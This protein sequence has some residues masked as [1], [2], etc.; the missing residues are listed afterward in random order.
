[1]RPLS[2]KTDDLNDQP[3]LPQTAKRLALPIHVGAFAAPTL[4][5]M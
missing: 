4:T 3:G 1:M 5:R 2:H